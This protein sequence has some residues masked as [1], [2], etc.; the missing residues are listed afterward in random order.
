MLEN[1][2]E[3]EITELVLDFANGTESGYLSDRITELVDS[4]TPIYNS[5][6]ITEWQ[7]MPPEFDG[8]GVVTYGLPPT[9]EINPVSLM[10]LDLINYIDELVRVKANQV[11]EQVGELEYV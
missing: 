11:I 3:E 7:A 6:I 9:D 8:M 5:D 1:W 10:R 2:Q 4:Y